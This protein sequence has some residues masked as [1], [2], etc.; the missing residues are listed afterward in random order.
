[1][2]SLSLHKYNVLTPPPPPAVL[3][4][5]VLCAVLCTLRCGV[6][7]AAAIDPDNASILV[8]GGGGVG[9]SVTR[10]VKDMGSWVC[11]MELSG[12]GGGGQLGV[13]ACIAEGRGRG[14]G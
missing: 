13:Q 6:E 3:C 14:C 11:M 8:C 10:K 7:A 1:V 9:L 12:F 4:C 2:R 5:A